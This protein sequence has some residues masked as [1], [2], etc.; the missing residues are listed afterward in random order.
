M[1][2]KNIAYLQLWWPFCSTESQLLPFRSDTLILFGMVRRCALCKN[3][4]SL[5]FVFDL[6]PLSKCYLLNFVILIT[7]IS[8]E[9][10]IVLSLDIYQGHRALLGLRMIAL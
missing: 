2:F 1:W 7:C 10:L 9:S 4:C 8:F 3:D 6:S 5:C